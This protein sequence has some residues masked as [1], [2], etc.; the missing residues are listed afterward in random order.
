MHYSAEGTGCWCQRSDGNAP[1]KWHV[2]GDALAT[3]TQPMLFPSLWTPVAWLSALGKPLL[4]RA[5][6]TEIA[7]VHGQWRSCSRL[8][9]SRER[10]GPLSHTRAIPRGSGNEAD[11]GRRCSLRHARFARVLRA[12]SFAE[13]SPFALAAA[14]YSFLIVTARPLRQFSL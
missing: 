1:D 2:L 8:Q 10:S 11:V 12:I 5:A 6:S 14:A 3:S 4:E 13:E 7:P 9:S